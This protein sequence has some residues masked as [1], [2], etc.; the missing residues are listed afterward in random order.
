MAMPGWSGVG[1]AYDLVSYG[2]Q[3]G[4]R[5]ATA[6]SRAEDCAVAVDS[7]YLS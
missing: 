4:A 7:A 6:C 3:S 1:A 2:D 5:G